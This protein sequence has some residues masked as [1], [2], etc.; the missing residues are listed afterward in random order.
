MVLAGISLLVMAQ[1]APPKVHDLI[2]AKKIAVVSDEGLPQIIL[3]TSNL[4]GSIITLNSKAEIAIT[5]GTDD[6]RN[7]LISTH[8]SKGK[9]LV[10][11]AASS[12]SGNGTIKTYDSGGSRLIAITSMTNGDET[13]VQLDRAGKARRVW[14]PN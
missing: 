3:G 2:R 12:P 6:S 13:I 11:I 10:G 9:K 1:A 4:G 14:P 8:S 7:G 5:L